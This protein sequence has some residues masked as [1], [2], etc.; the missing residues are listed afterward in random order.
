M[1]RRIL[2]LPALLLSCLMFLAACEEEAVNAAYDEDDIRELAYRALY[3][4]LRIDTLG[5]A[6]MAVTVG[7]SL[8]DGLFWPL[9]IHGH[10][11]AFLAR[12]DD[13]PIRILHMSGVAADTVAPPGWGLLWRTRDTEEAATACFTG[14]IERI[15]A[16]HLV[17][18]CG[19]FYRSTR[20]A[21][22]AFNAVYE[23]SVWKAGS[24]Q[25]YYKFMEDR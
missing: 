19:M 20:Q 25:Y 7:D 9:S 23:N 18:V 4:D 11:D 24:L 10:S 21:Y 12:L 5:C 15:D 2:C 6:A 3:H 14:N 22:A 16:T 13:L 17:L 8:R 1:R